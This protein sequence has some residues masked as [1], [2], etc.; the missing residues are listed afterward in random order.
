MVTSSSQ[1]PAKFSRAAYAEFLSSTTTPRRRG[2]NN[3]VR[4]ALAILVLATYSVVP[5]TALHATELA[6]E[7]LARYRAYDQAYA[8]GDL[9]RAIELARETRDLGAKALGPKHDKLA[10]VEINLGHVL[11]LNRQFEQAIAPLRRAEDIMTALKRPL[12]AI[13]IVA[14]DDLATAYI[15]LAQYDS[16]RSYLDKRIQQARVAERD[17]DSTLARAVAQRARL[18]TALGEREKAVAI[19]AR[20]REETTRLTGADSVASAELDYEIALVLLQDDRYQPAIQ[21]LRT[22]LAI[23]AEA[24]PQSEELSYRVHGALAAAYDKVGDQKK[25]REHSDALLAA[26]TQTDGQAAPIL[27]LQPRLDRRITNSLDG[28]ALFEFDVTTAGRVKNVKPLESD[29]PA[30]ITSKLAATVANWR[31]RPLLSDGRAGEAP[32]QRA[33]LRYR[34]GALTIEVG[35]RSN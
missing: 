24:Q 2:G 6:D 22:A 16:A 13:L 15:Q 3:A 4:T 23:A 12:D 21:R 17:R 5:C 27:I 11:L 29:L 14:F 25:L 30:G 34:A 1:L 20:G 33:K 32:G 19:L 7:F 8:E 10:V 26:V 31:Y 28:H 35:A 18:E 9:P